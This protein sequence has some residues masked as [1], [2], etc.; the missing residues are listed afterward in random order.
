M[1]RRIAALVVALFLLAAPSAFAGGPTSVILVD[2]GSGKTASLYT[3]DMNYQKLLEALGDANPDPKAPTLH[4]G[5]GSSAVNITWLIHDVQVWRIDHV[6]L[7]EDGGPWI[8][9]Y[10]SYDGQIM[11]DQRGAIHRPVDPQVTQSLVAALLDKP[12]TAVTPIAAAAPV[13]PPVTAPVATGLQWGSL[14]VG[15]AVGAL[16]VVG[17]TTVRRQLRRN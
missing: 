17:F 6:F 16:L 15:L 13:V 2:P 8:E 7:G 12:K 1:A 3:G 10:Q 5:P 14:L 11:F 4:G 9:T